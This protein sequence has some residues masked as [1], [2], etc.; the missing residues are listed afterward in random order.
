[1]FRLPML[2][3][4]FPAIEYLGQI[5]GVFF[6]D[7]GVAWDDEF[8]KYNNKDSWN[9]SSNQNGN[10]W[11]MSYGLGPRFIFL[12]M[13]WKLDYAWQ[14]DPYEGKKSDKKWYLSIGLDF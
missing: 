5:F 10:G 13:P 7:M 12:G 2:V 8:P 14:Y 11:I 9:Y 6:V 1:M 4:Y 3:Y